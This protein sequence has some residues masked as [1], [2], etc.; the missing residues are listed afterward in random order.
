MLYGLRAVAASDADY[1]APIAVISDEFSIPRNQT[2]Q[3]VHHYWTIREQLSV[4]NGLVLFGRRIVILSSACRDVLHK[5]HAA[6]QGIVRMK[7][8]A[9]QTVL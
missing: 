6:H 7:R 5:L 8:R 1:S 4:E 2:A 3:C 9:R